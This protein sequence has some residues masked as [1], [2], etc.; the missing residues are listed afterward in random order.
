VFSLGDE[1][2]CL[3]DKFVRVKNE[4]Q[5]HIQFWQEGKEILQNMQDRIQSTKSKLAADL[6]ESQTEDIQVSKE[7]ESGYRGDHRHCDHD[8]DS[9]YNDAESIGYY[10][11]D[12]FGIGLEEMDNDYRMI[13][14]RDLKRGQQMRK[15]DIINPRLS[16]KDSLF[17]HPTVG[18]TQPETQSNNAACFSSSNSDPVTQGFNHLLAFV[19]GATVDR[20]RDFRCEENSDVDMD[21]EN[22]SSHNNQT[23]DCNFTISSEEWNM[24]GIS[25]DFDNNHTI[26]TI[27]EVADRIAIEKGINLDR[28]QYVAYRIICSS[29]MLGVLNEGWDIRES[30]ISELADVNN[31]DVERGVKEKIADR[32]RE[33]GGKDQQ[34]M[35]ITGPAGAGKSTSLEVAQHFC[36]SFCRCIG[37][38]WMIQHLGIR[39]HPPKHGLWRLPHS[40]LR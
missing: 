19:S 14:L 20:R 37:Y 4:E 11:D 23:N 25:P 8:S 16:C 38:H 40:F 18:D 1:D 28:I 35:F 32:L 27:K 39:Q 15:D 3:W 6:L 24:L 30:T 10:E 9:E 13:D 22:N 29:F 31:I 17:T 36:F 7:D 5:P 34:I 21:S 12:E 2:T 26:P 33:I